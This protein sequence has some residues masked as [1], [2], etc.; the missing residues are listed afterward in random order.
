VLGAFNLK[1]GNFK[2][3]VMS[4]E[5]TLLPINSRVFAVYHCGAGTLNRNRTFEH[6]LQDWSRIREFLS[7]GNTDSILL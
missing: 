2:D 1:A 3:A 5:P 6:Q 7:R 4:T